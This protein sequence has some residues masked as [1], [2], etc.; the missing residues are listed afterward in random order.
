MQVTQV[1]LKRLL[2]QWVE[3]EKERWMAGHYTDMS[4]YGTAILNAKAIGRCEAI[5]DI[6]NL[7]YETFCME[8]GYEPPR[9]DTM[10][11]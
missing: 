2:P 9:T 8:L 11:Q 1:L 6:L 10:E 4:Q 7:D 3:E 5:H